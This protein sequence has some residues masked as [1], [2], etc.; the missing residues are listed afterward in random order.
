MYRSPERIFKRSAFDKLI[1]TVDGMRSFAAV[2]IWV[3]RTC[4]RSTMYTI[5]SRA[6]FVRH[7]MVKHRFEVVE[8]NGVRCAFEDEGKPP[9]RVDAATSGKFRRTDDHISKQESDRGHHAEHHDAKASVDPHQRPQ[10]E[11]VGLLNGID[12]LPCCED[13]PWITK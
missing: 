4:D 7:D 3:G 10:L 13:P 2:A 5:P 11:A 1:A 9:V 8:E 12:E 6:E